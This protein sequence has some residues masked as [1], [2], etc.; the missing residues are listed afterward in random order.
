MRRWTGVPVTSVRIGGGYRRRN[1]PTIE[2]ILPH[3]RP[4]SYCAPAGRGI[5]CEEDGMSELIV[6]E[7]DNPVKARAALH[8]V[9]AFWWTSSQICGEW[10]W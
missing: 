3:G 9:L 7:F 4:C 10:R 1:R 6:I 5:W 2:L 8:E